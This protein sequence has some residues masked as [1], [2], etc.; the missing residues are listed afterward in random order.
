VS[1]SCGKGLELRYGNAISPHLDS[2]LGN[3]EQNNF[4]KIYPAKYVL[5]FAEGT[6]RRKVTPGVIST[7][8]RNLSQIPR[9]HSG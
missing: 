3:V 9:I 7:E 6:P 8:G 5:S 1:A 2:Y 4:K